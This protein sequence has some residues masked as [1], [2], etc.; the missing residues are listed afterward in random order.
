MGCFY[1]HFFRRNRQNWKFPLFALI[2]IKKDLKRSFRVFFHSLK[3][4]EISGIEPL[5]F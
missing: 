2:R 3:L 1:L 4:V 5:T